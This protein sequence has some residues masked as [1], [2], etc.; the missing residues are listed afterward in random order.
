[1]DRSCEFTFKLVEESQNIIITWAEGDGVGV[2]GGITDDLIRD[3][4]ICGIDEF[5]GVGNF[6]RT[7]TYGKPVIR[8]S[9]E[10]RAL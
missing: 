7:D 3:T 1:M 9:E 8:V 10:K 6:Y 2:G 4:V 5:E